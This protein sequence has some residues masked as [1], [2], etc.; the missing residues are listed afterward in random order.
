[1]KHGDTSIIS[2]LH[3]NDHGGPVVTKILFYLTC[4][5]TAKKSSGNYLF[6]ML[7]AT[8]PAS[9]YNIHGSEDC[10]AFSYTLDFQTV[11]FKLLK[12]I[13][14][15]QFFISLLAYIVY[16]VAF[17]TSPEIHLGERVKCFS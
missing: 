2:L 5:V 1:M 3:N 17:L 15:S 6:H 10:G 4:F 14:Q 11:A 9:E 13:Y 12:N 7:T 16:M 8:T